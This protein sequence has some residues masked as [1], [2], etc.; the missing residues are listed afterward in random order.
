MVIFIAVIK[1]IREKQLLISDHSFP[2]V[3]PMTLLVILWADLL[4]GPQVG[5]SSIGPPLWQL[6]E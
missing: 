2:R 5:Y 6:S 3:Q 1:P 4:E